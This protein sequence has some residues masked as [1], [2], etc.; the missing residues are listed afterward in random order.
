MIFF[1]LLFVPHGSLAVEEKLLKDKNLFDT[2]SSVENIKLPAP[3]GVVKD[4]F[5]NHTAH[6]NIS[7]DRKLICFKSKD[8][9]D[10][11]IIILIKYLNYL[12]GFIA[13]KDGNN[14]KYLS[15]CSIG[16]K[17]INKLKFGKGLISF[18]MNRREVENRFG[19]EAGI[20]DYTKEF[21]KIIMK[22]IYVYDSFYSKRYL[23]KTS[24]GSKKINF[25]FFRVSFREPSEKAEIKRI[26]IIKNIINQDTKK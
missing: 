19:L 13:M 21:N 17:I 10:K 7:P 16:K 8:K 3:F 23:D 11:S 20:E 9:S 4:L 22:K 6:I 1:A 12:I 26:D 2:L 18:N 24:S 5:G 15:K 14:Y 25:Y